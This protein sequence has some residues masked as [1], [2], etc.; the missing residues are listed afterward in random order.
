VVVKVNGEVVTAPGDI[1]RHVHNSSGKRSI[2]FVVMRNH[3]EMSLQVTVDDG[4][5]DSDK[6]EN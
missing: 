6:G 1:S 4:G 3:R 5:R 2:P